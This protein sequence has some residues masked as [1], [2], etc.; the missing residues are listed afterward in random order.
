MVKI[1]LV[2]SVLILVAAAVARLRGRPNRSTQHPERQRMPRLVPIVG[3]LL[4]AAGVLLGL[5]AFTAEDRLDM[6]WPMRIAAV[7][8]AIAGVV[9]LVMYRNFYV[10]P[11]AD[12]IAFRTVFGRERVIAYSDLVDYDVHGSGLQLILTLRAA[13]G[14][15]LRLNVR[16]YDMSPFLRAVEFRRHHG[17]WPVRGEALGLPGSGRVG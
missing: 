9:F 15:R 14:P 6:L 13:S 17:R 5:S 10:A 16:L 4:L 7:L 8:M 12:E 1:L 3:A 11:R 2:L